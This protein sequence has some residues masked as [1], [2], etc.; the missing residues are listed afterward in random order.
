MKLFVTF[1]LLSVLTFAKTTH[2]LD[3]QGCEWANDLCWSD[4]VPEHNDDVYLTS[5]LFSNHTVFSVRGM[6]PL[7]SLRIGA[8][9]CYFS[10]ELAPAASFTIN[11][12]HYISGSIFGSGFFLLL[13]DSMIS[14]SFPKSLHVPLS[15]QGRLV[16]SSTD[17]AYLGLAE[18]A[19]LL[20]SGIIDFSSPSFIEL[21]PDQD[22][23]GGQN[24]NFECTRDVIVSTTGTVTIDVTF[25]ARERVSIES[26]TLIL[27]KPGD[28]TAQFA[29]H[30][31]LVLEADTRFGSDS[32]ITQQGRLIITPQ[33]TV[34]VNGDYNFP[35]DLIIGEGSLLRFVDGSTT[36]SFLCHDA[37]ESSAVIWESSSSLRLN[38]FLVDVKSGYFLIESGASWNPLGSFTNII[39]LDGDAGLEFQPSSGEIKLVSLSVVGNST[40][41][42]ESGPAAEIDT[43]ILGSGCEYELPLVSGTDV[44]KV[45]D[46]MD[47]FNG[48]LGN[49]VILSG[50]F[51]LHSSTETYPAVLFSNVDFIVKGNAFINGTLVISSFSTVSFKSEAHLYSEFPIILDDETSVAFESTS[52]SYIK[53]R[54]KSPIL[55]TTIGDASSQVSF[56]GNFTVNSP[57]FIITPNVSS[58]FTSNSNF[59]LDKH[60]EF[61]IESTNEPLINSSFSLA[62]GSFV[63]TSGNLIFFVAD[64]VVFGRGQLNPGFGGEIVFKGNY[65]ASPFISKPS[66]S[67]RFINAF[68]KEITVVEGLSG[69]LEFNNCVYSQDIWQFSSIKLNLVESVFI[70]LVSSLFVNEFV[71]DNGALLCESIGSLDSISINHFYYSGFVTFNH[72][73][74]KILLKTLTGSNDTLLIKSSQSEVVS[75]NITLFGRSVLVIASS[76]IDLSFP[77]VELYDSSRFH[78]FNFGNL[79]FDSINI[80]GNST[81]SV[82]NLQNF[83]IQKGTQKHESHVDIVDVSSDVIFLNYSV[84]NN[85]L[86]QIRNSYNVQGT[87][88]NHANMELSSVY[89]IN[90]ADFFQKGSNSA[91]LFAIDCNSISA[92]LFS[93]FTGSV[94]TNNIISIDFDY[95]ELSSTNQPT[96]VFLSY[97]DSININCDLTLLPNSELYIDTV[98]STLVLPLINISGLLDIGYL[99]FSLEL[100][101]INLKSDAILNLNTGKDVICLDFFNLNDN[102]T[103]SGTDALIVKKSSL[104]TGG[105]FSDSGKTLFEE[106]VEFKSYDAKT[107]TNNAKV[108]LLADSIVNSDVDTLYMGQE[109]ELILG[110]SVNFDIH[111]ALFIVHLPFESN[112]A[113]FIF[114]SGSIVNFKQS[115]LISPFLQGTVTINVESDPVTLAGGGDLT[116]SIFNVHDGFVIFDGICFDSTSE[117]PCIEPLFFEIDSHSVFKSLPSSI[118]T[119]PNVYVSFAGIYD[120]EP[121]YVHLGGIFEFCRSNEMNLDSITSIG[122]T[123]RSVTSLSQ[124][125][126]NCFTSLTS[127]RGTIEFIDTHDIIT[128]FVNLIGGYLL[129]DSS[130]TT[131]EALY[132]PLTHIKANS[133]INFTDT[134]A[135]LENVFFENG[136]ICAIKS[137]I[138]ISNSLSVEAGNFLTDNA[139]LII[140]SEASVLFSGGADKQLLENSQVNLDGTLIWDSD[141]YFIG[142]SGA[143]FTVVEGANITLLSPSVW[144][145]S[146]VSNETRPLFHLASPSAVLTVMNDFDISWYIYSEAQIDVINDSKFRVAGGGF[147][148]SDIVLCAS[149]HLE[150]VDG[151]FKFPSHSRLRG[152]NNNMEGIFSISDS[153]SVLIEGLFSLDPN[154]VLGSGHL[155][156]MKG[157]V[158]NIS[159]LVVPEGGSIEFSECPDNGFFELSHLVIEGSVEFSSLKCDVVVSS[160]IIKGGSLSFSNLTGSIQILG[161][162]ISGGSMV[163]SELVEPLHLDFL[164]VNGTHVVFDTNREV[165]I[166]NMTLFGSSKISGPDIVHITDYFT[167]FGGD[168]SEVSVIV[169]DYSH[170]ILSSPTSKSMSNASI[171]VSNT[172]FVDD[173]VNVE[174]YSHSS[175]AFSGHSVVDFYNSPSF[176][177]NSLSSSNNYFVLNGTSSI[178]FGTLKIDIY[179]LHYG[180]LV[181]NSSSIVLSYGGDVYGYMEFFGFGTFEILDKGSFIFHSSSLLL[182]SNMFFSINYTDRNSNCN[183]VGNSPEVV[184]YG[185]YSLSDDNLFVGFGSIYFEPGSTFTITHLV[186]HYPAVVKFSGNEGSLWTL[187]YLFVSGYLEV[188]DLHRDLNIVNFV[189]IGTESTVIWEDIHSPF[190]I[191]QAYIESG[192]THFSECKDLEV[193]DFSLFN[194]TMSIQQ[195]AN[196]L[197]HYLDF[198]YSSISFLENDTPIRINDIT[199]EK[200]SVFVSNTGHVIK[201][202]RIL[203]NDSIV[204]GIDSVESEEFFFHSGSVDL[205]ITSQFIYFEKSFDKVLLANSSITVVNHAVWNEGFIIGHSLA[206]IIVDEFAYFDLNGESL[207]YPRSVKPSTFHN[208]PRFIIKGQASKIS[209]ADLICSFEFFIAKF[210]SFNLDKGKLYLSAGGES[211][212]VFYSK[213]SSHLE[214]GPYRTKFGY[215]FGFELLSFGQG[216][217][218]V[219]NGLLSL[220]QYST[221]KVSGQFELLTASINRGL[222]YF[223]NSANLTADSWS[224]FDYCSMVVRG[225]ELINFDNFVS[226]HNGGCIYFEDIIS[227]LYIPYLNVNGGVILFSTGTDVTIGVFDFISGNIEGTDDV[228]ITQSGFWKNGR[229]GSHRDKGEQFELV[230]G[231]NSFVLFE[232]CYL[233]HLSFNASVTN[234]GTMAFVE[235][236]TFYSY[237]NA[238]FANN[239]LLQ[240]GHLCGDVLCSDLDNFFF[241]VMDVNRTD[242]ADLPIFINNGNF[243]KLPDTGHLTNQLRFL[244]TNAGVFDL[245]ST[246]FRQFQ[247]NATLDGLFNFDPFTTF[248]V[249]NSLVIVTEDAVFDGLE[250]TLRTNGL[251][252]I[253]FSGRYNL[254]LD[255]VHDIGTF[256]FTNKTCIDLDTI[257]I[258]DGILNF[259]EGKERS[260][261]FDFDLL[262]IHGGKFTITEV[263]QPFFISLL[264][265]TDGELIVDAINNYLTFDAVDFEGGKATFKDVLRNTT[266]ISKPQ[267]LG[268]S[269]SLINSY[270]WL[271]FESGLYVETGHTLFISN[272]YNNVWTPESFSLGGEVTFKNLHKNLL[273]DDEF[274]GTDRSV[275][276][277][278][279]VEGTVRVLTEIKT[280]GGRTTFEDVGL[281]FYTPKLTAILGSTITLERVVDVLI[282]DQIRVSARLT[283]NRFLHLNSPLF[284]LSGNADA[285]IRNGDEYVNITELSG[286]GGE[287]ELI[288][289]PLLTIEVFEPYGTD[290]LFENIQDDFI[291]PSFEIKGGSL[292][293]MKDFSGDFSIILYDVE[294][295][296]GTLR[297]NTRYLVNID[298]LVLDGAHRHTATRDGSDRAVV[299]HEIHFKGGGFRGGITESDEPLIIYTPKDKLIHGSS[300]KLV[301]NVLC[302]IDVDNGDIRGDYSGT[303]E[304]MNV[305]NVVGD[306]VFSVQDNNNVNRIG[307]FRNYGELYFRN[308]TKRRH[309]HWKVELK[310]DTINEVLDF[311]FALGTGGGVIETN[312]TL[313]PTCLLAFNS[314]MNQNQDT[315]HLFTPTSA[316]SCPTCRLDFRTDG[317]YVRFNGIFDL[318]SDHTQLFGRLFFLEEARHPINKLVIRR[319][320]VSFDRSIYFGL[321]S[322]QNF[323]YES[324]VLN[325]CGRLRHVRSI[326]GILFPNLDISGGILD[327]VHHDLPFIIPDDQEINNGGALRLTDFDYDWITPSLTVNH[328]YLSLNTGNQVSIDS[329]TMNL[330]DESDFFS[331]DCLRQ[332]GFDRKRDNTYESYNQSSIHG[333]DILEVDFLDWNGGEL[334][335]RQL[336]VLYML[337]SSNAK[338]RGMSNNMDLNIHND[339]FIGGPGDVTMDARDS[340]ARVNIRVL[341]DGHARFV[342]PVEFN[343]RY[344]SGGRNRER[345]HYL[346]NYG[347][348]DFP[349]EDIRVDLELRVLQHNI[350]TAADGATVFFDAPSVSYAS[351]RYFLEEDAKLLLGPWNH[352]FREGNVASGTGNMHLHGWNPGNRDHAVRNSDP[353]EWRLEVLFNGYWDLSHVFSQ[354]NGAWYFG[355]HAILNITEFYLRDRSVL[356]IDHSTSVTGNFSLDVFDVAT[357]SDVYIYGLQEPVTSKVLRMSSSEFIRFGQTS[358]ATS[359]SDVELFNGEAEFS[360]THDLTLNSL[361]LDGGHKSGSDD[362]YVNDLIWRCGYISGSGKIYVSRI[363]RIEHCI[364][365]S[366]TKTIRDTSRIVFLPSAQLDIDTGNTVRLQDSSLITSECPTTILR[367]R[368]DGT[369]QIVSF[370]GPFTIVEGSHLRRWYTSISIRNN[371]NHTA[372]TIRFRG[373]L[374]VYDDYF[375]QDSCRVFFEKS[376][377]CW[378]RSYNA[379]YIFHDTSRVIEQLDTV[380][381]QPAQFR[382]DHCAAHVEVRHV[383]SFQNLQFDTGFVTFTGPVDLSISRIHISSNATLNFHHLTN[384]LGSVRGF[385]VIDDA[386]MSF[387]TGIGLVTFDGYG[388]LDDRGTIKG[389]GDNIVI[390]STDINSDEVFEWRG[391]GFS[392]YMVVDIF[393][394]LDITSNSAKR[395]ENMVHVIIHEEVRWTGSGA[396]NGY[397]DSTF[398]ISPTGSLTLTSN[399]E[400]VCNH[401]SGNSSLTPKV[402]DALFVINGE[403][404]LMPFLVN[405]EF[406]IEFG[407]FEAYAAVLGNGNFTIN[408]PGTLAF[409]SES[410]LSVLGPTSRVICHGE[411]RLYSNAVVHLHGY[412][413][414]DSDV[415]INEGTLIFDDDALLANSFN[416]EVVYGEARFKK[417]SQMVPLRSVTCHY[418]D[419]N[420]FT[421]TLITITDL[422]LINGFSGGYDEVHVTNHLDWQGG[423]FGEN[424]MVVILNT[425]EAA[426]QGFDRFMYNHSVL[427]NRGEFDVIGFGIFYG[428]EA[429]MINEEGAEMIFLQA[430]TWIDDSCSHTRSILLN[431]GTITIFV[432]TFSNE[433]Y[434]ENYGL[435]DLQFGEFIMTGGGFSVYE[436]ICQPNTRIGVVG[437]PFTFEDAPGARIVGSGFYFIIR[438]ATGIIYIKTE[439]SLFECQVEDNGHLIITDGARITEDVSLTVRGTHVVFEKFTVVD[440]GK[441]ER[442]HLRVQGIVSF[443]TGLDIHLDS[444]TIQ[445]GFRGGSDTLYIAN[446]F[447][448]REGGGFF[449]SGDKQSVTIAEKGC[450]IH[451]TWEKDVGDFATVIFNGPVEWR[452]D[453]PIV[454]GKNARV[455]FNEILQVLDGGF[456][457]LDFTPEY[458]I[459]D[460]DTEL[461]HTTPDSLPVVY[462]NNGMELFESGNGF[463][464]EWELQNSANITIPDDFVMKVL[465]GGFHSNSSRL[466]SSPGSTLEVGAPYPYIF[467]EESWFYAEKSIIKMTPGSLMSFDG[468]VCFDSAVIG[469]AGTIIIRENATMCRPTGI[470]LEGTELI[471]EEDTEICDFT[472]KGDY[473]FHPQDN[474]SIT[475]SF[476]WYRGVIRV[477]SFLIIESQATFFLESDPEINQPKEDTIYHVLGEGTSFVNYGSGL[478]KYDLY[479]DVGAKFVNKGDL[480]FQ[481]GNW[482]LLDNQNASL[483][484]LINRNDLVIET[485]GVVNFD[486]NITQQSGRFKLK[487]GHFNVNGFGIVSDQFE[488]GSDTILTINSG[489]TFFN[490]NV[491]LY[492]PNLVVNDAFITFSNCS[493][494]WGDI[495]YDFNYE[496]SI[497]TFD[498]DTTIKT[499]PGLFALTDG[500]IELLDVFDEFTLNKF[501]Q[502]GGLLYVSSLLFDPIITNYQFQGGL[503]NSASAWSVADFVFESGEFVGSEVFSPQKFTIKTDGEKICNTN[504]NTL[505]GVFEFGTVLGTDN[506][507]ISSPNFTIATQSLAKLEGCSAIYKNQKLLHVKSGTFKF[508]FGELN[509]GEVLVD[510]HLLFR[511]CQ[512]LVNSRLNV[513]N[514]GKVSFDSEVV[515]SES[516]K[517]VGTGIIEINSNVVINGIVDFDGCFVIS[518]CGN[519]TLD[520]ATVNNMK[521]C[522]SKF[523]LSPNGINDQCCGPST[524]PCLSVSNIIE[525]MGNNGTIIL[526]EGVYRGTNFDIDLEFLD[527]VFQGEG[528]SKMTEIH[529]SCEVIVNNSNLEFSFVQ[530]IYFG[531]SRFIFLAESTV[532]FNK[533]ELVSQSANDEPLITIV[534]SRVDFDDVVFV[535]YRSQFIVATDSTI[536]LETV[537][538][539]DSKASG[540]V[541]LTNSNLKATDVEFNNLEGKVFDVK[542]GS[543]FDGLR[544]QIL[545]IDT[546]SEALMKISSSKF[547]LIDSQILDSSVFRL[548]DSISKSEI[549]LTNLD[550]V[551]LTSYSGS[552]INAD[553]STLDFTNVKTL[554]PVDSDGKVI[555]GCANDEPLITLVKSNVVFV[556]VDVVGCQ[557]QSIVATDSTIDLE[558]VLVRDS[559]ATDSHFK[560]TN[561][562]LKARNIFFQN[563]FS[564]ASI[565]IQRASNFQSKPIKFQSNFQSKSLLTADSSVV[566]MDTFIIDNC[567]FDDSINYINDSVVSLSNFSN[568]ANHHYHGFYFIESKSSQIDLVGLVFNE[569]LLLKKGVVKSFQSDYILNELVFANS[570]VPL[571][572]SVES[573]LEFYS[574]TFDNVTLSEDYSALEFHQSKILLQN[575]SLTN[576]YTDF[577]NTVPLLLCSSCTLLIK[578]CTVA[579][580]YGV[581]IHCINGSTFELEQSTFKHNESP[582]SP[583]ILEQ[584][585]NSLLHNYNVFESNIGSFGGCISI[586][587]P[588]NFICEDN[589][590]INSFA[591]HEGGSL[592]IQDNL[593]NLNVTINNNSFID[594]QANRAGGAMFINFLNFVHNFDESFIDV[595]GNNFHNCKANQWGNDVASNGFALSLAWMEADSTALNRTLA[596]S[597]MD[598]FGQFISFDEDY[599]NQ[600]EF[601]IKSNVFVEVYTNI[602][603]FSKQQI[604]VDIVF[605]GPTGTFILLVDADIFAQAGIEFSIDKLPDNNDTKVIV[606]NQGQ[607][608]ANFGYRSYILI[609]VV[610]LLLVL[611]LYFF[612]TRKAK[613]SVQN[614]N[615]GQSKSPSN[616]KQG[617]TMLPLYSKPSTQLPSLARHDEDENSH[618]SISGI[619]LKPLKSADKSKLD[620]QNTKSLSNNSSMKQQSPLLPKKPVT[621]VPPVVLPALKKQKQNSV[622]SRREQV[623]PNLP[624]FIGET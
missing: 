256:T 73:P 55:L 286:T 145:Q 42:L 86:L 192:W 12:F 185:N 234:N 321:E 193:L 504:L 10:L 368:F 375:I 3:E 309:L 24:P 472:L 114:K 387:E 412:F 510:S 299:H 215:A 463:T 508:N 401:R 351:A 388:V 603:D 459:I 233:K 280:T 489:F 23:N 343:T 386:T 446:Q 365:S 464:L 426:P 347:A 346:I 493:I 21:T 415:R 152:L 519:L 284:T 147:F 236:F 555:S 212:G 15:N 230:F 116:S 428:S 528:D 580:N 569:N 303:L 313:C 128:P 83:Q 85:S 213:D 407:T 429:Q 377:A 622:Q 613:D 16:F 96:S 490:S 332:I 547:S 275:V 54:V 6:F 338:G 476:T 124:Q 285:S 458:S 20:N 277:F 153:S 314:E 473:K 337:N 467:D 216:S 1:F 474:W 254:T 455:I 484:Y 465:S 7:S 324:V 67:L 225:S 333:T 317:S 13:E 319:G 449:S 539:R 60:T 532:V 311:E 499:S 326:Y 558:T 25:H 32:S 103:R 488:L 572:N 154:I 65:S 148:N 150:L 331:S 111:S 621:F 413:C 202:N 126:Y 421:N 11:D 274:S 451:D 91:S 462:V 308:A 611:V 48:H 290:F 494:Y 372:G 127:T 433:F 618:S 178:H 251:G 218:T 604:L 282:E 566:Q 389:T 105:R 379:K 381:L 612:V 348:L 599:S 537:L 617:D 63:S 457:L 106:T 173:F 616:L 362:I 75:S 263:S 447:D 37:G 393:N 2:Y 151:E 414:T 411:V 408:T 262:A 571:F 573:N 541:D 460:M 226:V 325:E 304:L 249:Y 270:D 595:F 30:G 354:G 80:G 248:D 560:L 161:M 524:Y 199:I 300:T 554:G 318:L 606:D 511:K 41:V 535:G 593:Y 349:T 253:V 155:Y 543:V 115:A 564:Q 210:G 584:S 141:G 345:Y 315:H 405:G 84:I 211:L 191:S 267:N 329:I 70:N 601:S 39:K 112:R 209:P 358:E 158:Y 72:L 475:C 602:I 553:D 450:V 93:I 579:D 588:L 197:I 107:I 258:H 33:L 364:S 99:D 359:F 548:I 184:F 176:V 257:T 61:L 122:G 505:S 334:A 562:N 545:N 544:L 8:D 397:D 441:F 101:S 45:S 581:L 113:N 487:K 623:F 323:T 98:E 568:N 437:D 436:V 186:I 137:D 240:F 207:F 164:D 288:T 410:E 117:V 392:G 624:N 204:T 496:N 402:C 619:S 255:F 533:M 306:F 156:F 296:Q 146:D 196:L 78:L 443:I 563:L 238:V 182:G 385:E 94:S 391:G 50:D 58:F 5:C 266:F 31:D 546:P 514:D 292:V 71:L 97:S 44:L 403:L 18:G 157:S 279:N 417:V 198:K 531:T 516:S 525:K 287:C 440:G 586:F 179:L 36:R 522:P 336:D 38:S 453:C 481:A 600:L 352:D 133:T 57:G 469:P 378:R 82:S 294:I 575:S 140:T 598:Y 291:V 136:T 125:G 342:D 350:F 477:G 120:L 482:V 492:S 17:T 131:E 513:S 92:N 322:G 189:Q 423:G 480:N 183:Y 206:S 565:N 271:V 418:G 175:L 201:T 357:T 366:R 195:L 214:L 578:E 51:Y 165:V 549:S 591:T 466:L 188:F 404:N 427:I 360:T 9:D 409:H 273:I 367:S 301:A 77:F 219:I 208:A 307:I 597:I 556:D 394:P 177:S 374:D 217:N 382:P 534:K 247:G 550:I 384:D 422:V 144:K 576:F 119:K 297:L 40:I 536:D 104:I 530:L 49:S 89:S 26:G 228:V 559:T 52:W 246:V 485:S 383:F 454:G 69:E 497:V 527:V 260:E 168:F 585:T 181:G 526:K 396:F 200:Q 615:N 129:F 495:D 574:C 47:W 272:V 610:V 589:L 509:G 540:H 353:R 223:G 35:G 491:R 159:S 439:F 445:G 344:P 121:N 500:L 587:S 438:E 607:D 19:I 221:L 542:S 456:F 252:E 520:S 312:I 149:C 395:L 470:I 369:G 399:T 416:L 143:A 335:I 356:T 479:G 486:W 289:L 102:S 108:E 190:F 330:P 278:S 424:A 76:A 110:D 341:A 243:I 400:L 160:L 561:S 373:S 570:N 419:V 222:I 380:S 620:D 517:I 283:I 452:R 302:T 132:L 448:W 59:T 268:G 320:Y 515:F 340:N 435:V 609:G 293:E 22:H 34:E 62:E 261:I 398:E 241:S 327:I 142:H 187:N 295:I 166:N 444:L 518:A 229:I 478:I 529:I 605:E 361:I 557:S 363:G 523:Y 134:S 471:F 259:Y 269:F 171:T 139:N 577:N 521:M 90:F 174:F 109:A 100:P 130:F 390:N 64:A 328:G 87:L 245:K 81:L 594:N 43:L 66:G 231:S 281:E 316:I 123:F 68:I 355:E 118:R 138:Y 220:H 507:V 461:A 406:N 583:I 376:G 169:G 431:Q 95:F 339:A 237:Q 506:C 512:T 242:S 265:Q 170:F 592:Y 551:D 244:Q 135:Y 371:F 167:W 468:F 432:S 538:V 298:H 194:A 276:L 608:K 162:A 14:S 501:K 483:P 425:A 498:K 502:T 582:L 239:G 163:F 172:A 224:C 203:L 567:H 205:Y 180:Y 227:H 27:T 46:K 74:G 420:F 88:V 503:I 596:V 310:P 232:D 442:L 430:L 235:D 590:F 56:A 370:H 4:G 614:F 552:F 29:L 79:N 264:K 434:F 305:T 250:A 53:P 28:L